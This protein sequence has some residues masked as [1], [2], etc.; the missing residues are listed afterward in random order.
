MPRLVNS[1]IMQ[2]LSQI[3]STIDFVPCLTKHWVSN[4]TITETFF[5]FFVTFVRILCCLSTSCL[6]SDSLRVQ[7][8]LDSV[9]PSLP[10]FEQ[11]RSRFSIYRRIR[12]SDHS[13]PL[14]VFSPSHTI[15][16]RLGRLH[17]FDLIWFD[18]IQ[19]LK[20]CS[21][22]CSRCCRY[23]T[24]NGPKDPDERLDQPISMIPYETRTFPHSFRTLNR[25][26]RFWFQLW[27]SKPWASR[28]WV[29]GAQTQPEISLFN[30]NHELLSLQLAEI[31]GGRT[32]CGRHANV[33]VVCGPVGIGVERPWLDLRRAG[34]QSSPGPGM[35]S[36]NNFSSF[37]NNHPIIQ[38]HIGAIVVVKKRKRNTELGK[39]G[40]V[41]RKK[42]RI[43]KIKVIN[44]QE[45]NLCS[46]WDS[47]VVNL[48]GKKIR[49]IASSQNRGH[50]WAKSYRTCSLS[51][52]IV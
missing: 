44:L 39:G 16:W 41:Q 52:L 12:K 25:T 34:S 9:Q 19:R 11:K 42:H 14:G 6:S 5:A 2:A 35:L 24:L 20:P 15:L 47:R 17:W 4:L 36:K 29:S 18:S 48:W 1:Y 28:L 45:K 51:S 3:W 27:V 33:W 38:R 8:P 43:S 26:L 23:S 31:F 30:K 7:L 37:C 40:Y 46:L 32:F 21:W 22:I 10:S 49:K 13:N 50:G